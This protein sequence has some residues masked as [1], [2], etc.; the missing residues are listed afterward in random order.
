MLASLEVDDD[1]KQVNHAGYTLVFTQS[2]TQM[3]RYERS[4]WIK[5]ME[6]GGGGA[7]T[8]GHVGTHTVE[9]RVILEVS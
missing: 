2:T 7:T 5:P 6:R 3:F 4:G 9:Q 8:S 1:S